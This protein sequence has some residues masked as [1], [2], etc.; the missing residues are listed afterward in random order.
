MRKL[1]RAAQAG[2]AYLTV[3]LPIYPQHM[4]AR[5]AIAIFLQRIQL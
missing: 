4:P 3:Q 5:L 1:Q 2:R